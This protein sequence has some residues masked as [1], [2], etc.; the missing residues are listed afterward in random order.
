[1][2]FCKSLNKFS[3]F[4]L[5]SIL[6]VVSTFPIS[7]NAE[8][9]KLVQWWDEYLPQRDEANGELKYARSVQRTYDADLDDDGAEDDAQLCIPFSATESL[10]PPSACGSNDQAWKQYRLD[11]PSA[12]FFGG[13]VANYANM[14]A[15]TVTNSSGEDVAAVRS[16]AQ[17]SVQQDGASVSYGYNEGYPQNIKRALFDGGGPYWA[18]MTLFA[19]DPSWT[20]MSEV[21]MAQEDAEVNF[22]AVY[23][24]QKA[25]FVNGGASATNIIFDESSRLSVDLVRHRRNVD[26]GRFL[27]QDGE[28]WWISEAT[29]EVE[30][31]GFKGI[32]AALNPLTSKWAPFSPEDCAL[33]FDA[34]NASFSDANF[35]DIQAVGVYFATPTFRHT[36][37][38]M[39][40]DNF[41]FYAVPVHADNTSAETDN[42]GTTSEIDSSLLALLEP[43]DSQAV[44][45]VMNTAG[46][47][48]LSSATFSRSVAV[49]GGEFFVHPTD[50][51]DLRGTIT[52]DPA[53][54]AQT[55]DL[56]V[57]IQASAGGSQVLFTL[58]EQGDVVPLDLSTY[59]DAR[60]LTSIRTGV[61]LLAEQIVQILP[62]SL[63]TFRTTETLQETVLLGC[64]ARPLTYS[65]ILNVG[66]GR[67]DFFYG[68]RLEDGSLVFGSEPITVN[69]GEMASSAAE[70]ASES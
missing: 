68:Y 13:V 14:S 51:L 65:G 33:F 50:Q 5:I 24:W 1:M 18:D 19:V 41:Q 7:A 28:Q 66:P 8:S 64:D 42:S 38:M 62:L 2:S 43:V 37:T 49:N 26:D 11:R 29:M 46:E 9:I 47:V 63:D 60:D 32:T 56:I 44:G 35:T 10:N 21:F 54:L 34:D 39:S 22:A 6:F 52:V 61:T 53:H 12:Q 17:G 23:M 27:V 4:P 55:A 57:L 15:S 3:R 40:F 30:E 31:G 36:E 69:V 58:N 67:L 45:M 59:Q 20:S 48:A 16:F 70:S 25:D